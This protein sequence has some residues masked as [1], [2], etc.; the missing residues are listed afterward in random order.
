MTRPHSTSRPSPLAAAFLAAA[1]LVLG[2]V[3]ARGQLVPPRMSDGVA[4]PAQGLASVDDA[5]AIY[6]N[7]A[8]LAFLPGAEARFTLIHT[9]DDSPIPNRGYSL[10]MAVPFWVLATGM[11]IDWMH[12]TTSAPPPYAHF[13]SGHNYEWVRWGNA[14]QLGEL[15]AL[16]VTMAWSHADE[17]HLD[18]HF[19]ATGG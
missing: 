5:S 12:P 8:N 19:S 4:T 11:R 17:P 16:G 7:P 6:R 1:T 3:P 18:G 2:S 14:V 9:G 13:G 15:A 10:D